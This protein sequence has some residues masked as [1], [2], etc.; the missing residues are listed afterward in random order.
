MIITMGQ[1]RGKWWKVKRVK[2]MAKGVQL[3]ISALKIE[4]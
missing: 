4:E 1:R 3:P 2:S